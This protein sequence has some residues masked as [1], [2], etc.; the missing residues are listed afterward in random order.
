M[1]NANIA[2]IQSLYAAFGRG[3]VASLIAGLTSDVDWQ[4]V[5]RPKDFPTLGPRKGTAQ[6]QEFFKLVA[7]NEDFSDFTP[8]EFYAADDKVFVLG[9]YA[10]KVR[11]TG[12]PV[13]SEWVH[14]FTLRDGKVTRFREHTDTAQFAEGYAGATFSLARRF[15]DEMCNGRKLNVADELFAAS[16]RYNDPGSPWVGQ[17]PAGMKDVIGTYHRGVKDARWDVQEMIAAGDAVLMRWTGTGTHTGDL[18]GIAPTNRKVRVDGLWMLRIADGKITESWN[19]WDT[20]GMLQQ[21][22]VVP[23]LGAKAA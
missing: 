3:D 16:H 11:K 17:G 9:T 22:G 15:V 20:L 8:R 19:C 10:L 13:S 23:Q 21:L 18:L 14:V 7:E 12:V 2:H 1:S 4:T 6:V 5:G